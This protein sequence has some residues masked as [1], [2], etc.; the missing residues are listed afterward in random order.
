MKRAKSRMKASKEYPRG[1]NKRIE[2]N[3][4]I[5]AMISL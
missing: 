5:P 1:G 4:L 3:I 2:K